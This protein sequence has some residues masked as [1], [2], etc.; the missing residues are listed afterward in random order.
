MRRKLLF[1][2]EAASQFEALKSNP[3]KVGLYRQVCKT[4]GFLEVNP[5]HPLTQH[6]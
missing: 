1:T 5:R 3:H 2:H 4:L 6:S